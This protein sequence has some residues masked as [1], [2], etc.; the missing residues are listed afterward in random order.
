LPKGR[1]II[2]A[3]SVLPPD[4][5]SDEAGWDA[6][7]QAEERKPDPFKL[8]LQYVSDLRKKGIERVWFPGCGTSLGPRAYAELGFEVLCSDFSSVS[9][10][11]LQR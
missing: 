2:N 11:A 9:V 8:G 4:D 6:Y 5:W 7:H 3:M 1:D 10:A